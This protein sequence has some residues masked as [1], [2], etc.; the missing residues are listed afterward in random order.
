MKKIRKV[1]F[2]YP[3][4]MFSEESTE[5][6]SATTPYEVKVPK[7]AFAFEF[8]TVLEQDAR[9]EDGRTIKHSEVEKDNVTYFPSGR[10]MT[11]E[12]VEKEVPDNRI[13]ISNIKNNSKD[14]K[15]IKTRM[16]NFQYYDRDKTRVI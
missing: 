1:K 7:N 6:T 10:I 3:G 13:L 11:I 2:L 14:N 15:V 8:Y 12:E 5:E 4:T 16:G 9:L